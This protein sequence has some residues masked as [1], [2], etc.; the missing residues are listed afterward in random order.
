MVQRPFSARKTTGHRRGVSAL[1]VIP[2]HA[3][4]TTGTRERALEG[5]GAAREPPGQRPTEMPGNA[6]WCFIALVGSFRSPDLVRWRLRL[7][8]ARGSG[9]R[10]EVAQVQACCS[11]RPGAAHARGR[12]CLTAPCAPSWPRQ[13]TWP[14]VQDLRLSSHVNSDHHRGSESW[15][16]EETRM[17]Y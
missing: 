2:E 17:N 10:P 9:Q 7:R 11:K 3:P 15:K 8:R 12:P 1:Q 14:H 5:A 13:Q 16:G 4:G 6:H